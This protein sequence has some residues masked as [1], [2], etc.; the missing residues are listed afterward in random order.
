V[1]ER[2]QP[3]ESLYQERLLLQLVDDVGLHLAQRFYYH[4]PAKIPS[5]AWVTV[6]RVRVKN[7]VEAAWWL[8]KTANPKADT[9]NVLQPSS[10]SMLRVLEEGGERRKRRPSGHGTTE[11]A[12]RRDHGGSIPSNLLTATNSSSS[13]RYHRLCFDHGLPPHPATFAREIPEFFIKF[14]T[15]PGDL[16][17]DPLSG[18]N[19]VGAVCERLKRKWLASERS[20]SYISGSK[21]R[22]DQYQ[23]TAPHL[24]AI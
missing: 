9:R 13:D 5:S 3:T 10:K 12:F 20:L 19:K 21:F 18:S 4:N 23:N 11:R 8:S 2:G 15:E 24:C 14:L 6:R 17:Y 7:V 22:F 1:W 16:V